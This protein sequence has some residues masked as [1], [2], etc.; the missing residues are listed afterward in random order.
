MFAGLLPGLLAHAQ[1]HARS[2]SLADSFQA[3]VKSVVVLQDPDEQE[4]QLRFVP[5][6]ADRAAHVPGLDDRGAGGQGARPIRS[7]EGNMAAH[8]PT[9]QEEVDAQAPVGQKLTAVGRLETGLQ[10]RVDP[11]PEL[12][13]TPVDVPVEDAH[14]SPGTLAVA[15]EGQ[16][17]QRV[18]RQMTGL[19]QGVGDGGVLA[20][21]EGG[22]VTGSD[23]RSH[24]AHGLT[25]LSGVSADL[26][27]PVAD[28][29]EGLT[30]RK[31]PQDGGREAARLEG[32][33]SMEDHEPASPA[34]TI[35]AACAHEVTSCLVPWSRRRT[36]RPAGCPES[37]SHLT[38]PTR[39]MSVA[40]HHSM[41]LVPAGRQPRHVS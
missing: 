31:G 21:D 40:S 26:H 3:G 12:A 30:H 4:V 2:R 11:L 25:P 39:H 18:R 20:V 24:P 32:E 13:E 37:I 1:C 41:S 29:G 17:Q 19:G 15:E 36:I 6:L 27:D 23:R 35:H 28:V 9:G 14:G 5:G 38:E 22:H 16:V 7:E 33:G 10:D 8:G 34:S